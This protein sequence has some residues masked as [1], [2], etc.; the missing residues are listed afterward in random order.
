M[1]YLYRITFLTICA[2]LFFESCTHVRM[3]S[4]R[5]P[6]EPL[7][8]PFYNS[9][10]EP[11][12]NPKREN[13]VIVML[14]RNGDIDGASSAIESLE[15]HFNKWFHYPMIFIND[16]EWDHAFKSRLAKI[17]SGETQFVTVAKR[18][19]NY[20]D[21]IKQEDVLDSLPLQKEM[22]S[23]HAE[24]ESYHH[25]CRFQS[26]RIFDHEAL[27]PYKWYWRVE[28]DIQYTCA[29]TYDPF[30]AMAESGKVYGYT[31]ALWEIGKTINGLFRLTSD[32]KKQHNVPTTDLWRSMVDPS[33]APF[34]I[35]P[36][37]GFFFPDRRDTNGDLWNLCHMWSNFEI[38]D[39]DFFRSKEYRAYFDALDRDGGFYYQRWGD[40]AVHSLAAALFLE[41]DQ[42]HYFSDFG[43]YHKP[44]FNCPANAA[45]GQLLQSQT[46]G[47]KAFQPEE[48]GGIGC[49][50]ECDSKAFSNQPVCLNKIRQGV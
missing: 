15:E 20:P 1:K 35:R 13:G 34:F 12:A 22:G 3:F 24:L 7:D 47:H 33:W 40:A 30:A 43:Y 8:P 31:V 28:P 14:A 48:E 37:L 25:M 4:V 18:D 29:I 5:P 50:C 23:L 21:W 45:G 44:F 17:A 6:P 38:A 26:G 42:L 41:P 19:W 11:P 46:L 10:Q 49:R 27:R 2:L 39:M 9:C 16:R 36:L 32:F